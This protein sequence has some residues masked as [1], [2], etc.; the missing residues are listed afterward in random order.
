MDRE[1]MGLLLREVSERI[2]DLVKRW[3]RSFDPISREDIALRVKWHVN[4]LLLSKDSSSAEEPRREAD[5][6]EVSFGQCVYLRVVDALRSHKRFAL[7]RRSYLTG[8]ARDWDSEAEPTEPMF[9]KP[10]STDWT[11]RSDTVGWFRKARFSRSN[12]SINWC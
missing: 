11:S 10:S 8:H 6:L 9:H 12:L 2:F 7:R 3:T 5:F 4:E 1:L